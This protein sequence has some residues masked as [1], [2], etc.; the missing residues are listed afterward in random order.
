MTAT[1]AWKGALLV[2]GLLILWHQDPFDHPERSPSRAFLWVAFLAA[3]MG[4]V[5]AVWP[6][7][8][9]LPTRRG[10]FALAAAFFL[11]LSVSSSE[12]APP[13]EAPPGWFPAAGSRVALHAR[14][15]VIRQI[16]PGLVLA[17]V[18]W[19]HTEHY[20]VRIYR[21]RFPAWR[22]ASPP[23]ET[24]P[25][26]LQSRL[27]ETPAVGCEL[28]LRLTAKYFPQRLEGSSYL[29]SIR[30]SG[31][32]SLVRLRPWIVRDQHCDPDRR[33]RIVER[34]AAAARS[35]GYPRRYTDLVPDL[36]ASP[37][38]EGDDATSDHTEEMSAGAIAKEAGSMS[39]APPPEPLRHLGPAARGIALG[40]V[41]G[42]AGYMDR[43]TK[44]TARVL[45]I[46]HVFAASGLHLALMYGLLY[47]PLSRLLGARHPLAAFL[48]LVPAGFYLW[49][50]DYPVSLAR[51][52]FF[53]LLFALRTLVH[54]RITTGD[55]LVNTALLSLLLFPAAMLSLSALLSFA[56]VAG[57][58]YGLAP[59]ERVFAPA[60]IGDGRP[61]G[62][63]RRRWAAVIPFFRQQAL[64]GMSASLL[65]T[66]V[67]VAFFQAYSFLSPVANLILVPLSNVLLPLIYVA[68][69][70]QV[71]WPGSTVDHIAWYAVVQGFDAMEAIMRALDLP[72][73]MVQTEGMATALLLSLLPLVCVALLLW[74][75]HREAFSPAHGRW[76]LLLVFLL[77]GPGGYGLLLVWRWC[78][79]LVGS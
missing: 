49:L 12:I 60:R 46:L 20:S 4:G 55:H 68:L 38:G 53:L 54:R 11:G 74:L 41:L 33:S 45:G 30:R 44:D 37:D 26:A 79:A 5:L 75:I 43:A 66:P 56:A 58:L 16:R 63:L 29:Q 25:V 1:R 73:F 32:S 48:P 21:K 50:L 17:H 42:Q 57:I 34:I 40:M 35:G 77:T 23:H 14:A 67:L 18:S 78:V 31:A 65:V 10:V 39:P 9:W 76:A 27:D 64:V 24:F 71:F 59:M 52:F 15:S 72:F 28:T 36:L 70:L 8:R 19:T 6:A 61:A 13:C 69:G 2:C 7:W 47:L 51:A 22:E 62:W 3:L